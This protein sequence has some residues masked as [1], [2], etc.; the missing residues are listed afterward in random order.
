MAAKS[1][2]SGRS[3]VELTDW[4]GAG[5]NLVGIYHLWD[6][7]VGL[8]GGLDSRRVLASVVKDIP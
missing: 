7:G 8:V 5:S 4:G 6:L 2:L 3:K 1:F